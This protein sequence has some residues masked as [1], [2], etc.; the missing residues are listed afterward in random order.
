M[1]TRYATKTDING[2][3]YQL[4]IDHLNKTVKKGYCLFCFKDYIKVNSK[5]AIHN[6]YDEFLKAGYKAF[7]DF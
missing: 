5:K 6:L 1:I 7:N 2:N 4:E 3:K